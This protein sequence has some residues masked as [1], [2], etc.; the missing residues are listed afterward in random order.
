MNERFGAVVGESHFD[1]KRGARFAVITLCALTIYSIY[2]FAV[3]DSFNYLV[4]AVPLVA[5]S[6]AAVY[7]HSSGFF[8][9][10]SLQ[11][12][13][14]CLS[15]VILGLVAVFSFPPYTVPDEGHHFFSTYWIT[16]V[17][18][19]DA[20]LS[21]GKG[22]PV[23]SDVVEMYGNSSIEI[24]SKGY[25]TVIE[26][27][28]AF[29]T[30]S[31]TE[32]MSSF[33]FTFGS[34]NGLAKIGSVFGVFIGRLFNL[35]AYPLF[36][37]GRITALAFFALCAVLAV[38]V[39]PV[40]KSAFAGVSLLPMTLSLAASY[41]Y[42]GGIIG[43]TM[44]FC[45]CALR[46]ITSKEPISFRETIVLGIL[47][48]I[49]APLKVVYSTALLLLFFIPSSRFANKKQS[50]VCK[51]GLLSIAC[52]SIMLFRLASVSSLAVSGNG[53]DYRGLE[54]GHYYELRDLIMHPVSS[55]SLFARTIDSM[56]DFYW[57]SMFGHLPGWL[58]Q[59]LAAPAFLIVPMLLCLLYS[60]QKSDEDGWQ[61]S[62][63]LRLS[64]IGGFLL[65]VGAVMLSMA[66][67]WTF[68]TETVIQG[69]QG[70][71][72]LP[73]LVLALVAARSSRVTVSGSSFSLCITSLFVLDCLYLLR[74][75]ALAF[76]L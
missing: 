25:R 48:A 35:G 74:F 9:V 7:F 23:R 65:T 59:N 56:G 43:L 27:F 17:I 55:L 69:V 36:Y 53:L 49:I 6:V 2:W 66:I 31:E 3:S 22:F 73:V 54:S 38:W 45:A 34:E 58:Q 16:D 5:A 61:P 44:L 46:A 60:I 10:P 52:A 28:Q 13:I 30:E 40:A 21:D 32:Q 50:L 18:T 11:I 26:E 24:S 12:K 4:V 68:D 37:L 75:A 41:S 76:S 20:G 72:F 67:G 29:S 42:D 1:G 64:C 57:L 39:T 15:L 63:A 14:F 62:L 70:R 33:D 8:D 19:G 47:A 71:Y 51:I